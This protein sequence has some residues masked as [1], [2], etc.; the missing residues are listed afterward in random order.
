VS[1]DRRGILAVAGCSAAIFWPGAL[2][3]AFPGVMGPVWREMFGVG[4]GAIGNALFFVLAS[5]GFFMFFVGRWQEK[6][7]SRMLV[8]IGALICSF[9][10]LL[11]TYA[12]NLYFFYLWAF[13]NGTAS[14]FIYMPGLTSVQRWYVERRGLVSGIFNLVFGLSAAV[15]APV[16]SAMLKSMGYVSM[17]LLL[18]A[19]SL[20]VGVTAAQFTETPERIKAVWRNAAF[21][22]KFVQQ[23]ALQ[24]KFL[25][26]QESLRTKSF[27]F[28]WLTWALQGSAGISMVSLS[29]AFGLSRELSMES[30]V[31]ILIAFNIMSG[32]SRILTGYISDLIGRTA[33]MSVTF[34][35]SGCAY[36]TLPHLNT[37]P[38]FAL[39]AGIIGFAFGTLFAVSA[40]LAS[41]CF[42]LKHFGAIFGLIFTAYGFISGALGPSLSGYLL[43]VTGGNY[44]LVFSYLGIFCIVSGF[45]IRAVAVPRPKG[46]TVVTR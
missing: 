6:V 3:F 17:N 1:A 39:L 41:D 30:A 32:L 33:T 14:C 24:G 28:L 43:D 38:G 27:W 21:D 13:L 46:I 26:V 29:V 22:E 44:Y 23:P 45:L 25:T 36:F 16:F 40:P 37:L 20:V 9:N 18:A 34:F 11:I 19:L 42:G 8:T 35:L 12:S 15:M 4:Q 2:V 31:T 5:L 7:G 10:I